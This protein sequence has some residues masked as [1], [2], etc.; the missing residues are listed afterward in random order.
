MF[1]LK[2]AQRGG[3]RLDVMDLNANMFR[4][5]SDLNV[6]PI[7]INGGNTGFTQQIR[8]IVTQPESFR[9]GFLFIN[10]VNVW[11]NTAGYP[12]MPNVD[13][14]TLT[15]T[16]GTN[17]TT[18]IDVNLTGNCKIEDPQGFTATYV[19]WRYCEFVLGDDYLYM[20]LN[21]FQYSS[22]DAQNGV[23][24][25]G[26][27]RNVNCD[28]YQIPIR[29]VDSYLPFFYNQQAGSDFANIV[30][31]TIYER[32]TGVC[33]ANKWLAT[34]EFGVYN[35]FVFRFGQGPAADKAIFSGSGETIDVWFFT[36]AKIDV[37]YLVGEYR[38]YEMFSYGSN[39]L[40][41][42]V[43]EDVQFFQNK[44][45]TNVE[46]IEGLSIFW[47][48][49]GKTYYP[50]IT[51]EP[52]NYVCYAPVIKTGIDKPVDMFQTNFVKY[53]VGCR[54]N[55]DWS[56]FVLAPYN[57]PA[58]QQIELFARKFTIQGVANTEL[59]GFI[60]NARGAFI[61]S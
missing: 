2:T 43:L 37:S 52:Q 51:T 39:K 23:F 9:I 59:D 4:I 27:R 21:R 60:N 38:H 7:Y 32:Y 30:D 35:P 44:I 10:R 57:N 1:D 50:D 33:S 12:P 6:K 34:L 28:V 15:D 49:T 61:I 8:T 46:W 22:G 26:Y 36:D 5:L 42:L 11:N 29:D 54:Y 41:H 3:E 17:I 53:L 40:V 55:E 13:D 14:V 25:F 20:V 58:N 45:I 19:S 47:K 24:D 16:T 18:T 31:Q 56:N 48:M